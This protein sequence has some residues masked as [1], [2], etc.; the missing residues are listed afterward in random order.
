MNQRIQLA[1]DF[2]NAN[3]HRRI[4]LS[5]LAEVANLSHYH[6]AH[7]FKDQTGLSPG[8]YLRV[9]KMEKASEL[10]AT[11]FFSVKEIMAMVGYNDKSHF[12]RHFRDAFGITPSEYRK[13]TLDVTCLAIRARA[14][15]HERK[16]GQRIAR[17][18]TSLVLHQR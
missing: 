11:T 1:I 4:R 5:E 17:L 18:T 10:L 14:R 16:T 8:I 15:G 3:L 9:L 12:A 7:L 13:G 2:M 6:L